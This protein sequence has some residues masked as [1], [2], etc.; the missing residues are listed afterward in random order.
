MDVSQSA[1]TEI[2]SVLTPGRPVVTAADH[3]AWERWKR[4]QKREQQRQ[5]RASLR[6][7]D[8]YPSADAATIID[9]TI[10]PSP[11]GDYSNVLDRIVTEWASGI[12]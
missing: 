6:R 4:H 5:R 9:A 2:E 3:T 10:S 11:G 1:T 8:Y 12:K 7:I